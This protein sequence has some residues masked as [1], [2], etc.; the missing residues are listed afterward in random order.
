LYLAKAGRACHGADVTSL[1]PGR[2]AAVATAVLLLAGS[3]AAA[4]SSKSPILPASQPLRL[5]HLA[6]A[7]IEVLARLAMPSLVDY[8]REQH[9]MQG[10]ALQRTSRRL[11]PNAF[12]SRLYLSQLASEQA[13]EVQLINAAVPGATVR[14]RL[15]TVL[16]A[17]A[18]VLPPGA[19]TR[20]A[21]VAGVTH[22]YPQ[23]YYH[24]LTDTV[25]PLVGA[26][27][28][29]GPDMANAGA[30]VKIGI[31]DDGIDKTN[32]FFRP[33]GFTAPAGFPRGDLKDTSNKVIVARAFPPFGADPASKLPFDPKVSEHGTHVAGIA[34]G[35]SGTLGEPKGILPNVPNLSGV[36]P[37]AYLGNYRGLSVADPVYG[38]VGGTSELAAAV[39]KAVQDGMD[40]LN[41]SLGGIE[42]PPQSDALVQA[43]EGAIH[44]GVVVSIAAGNSLQ[45]LGGGS[46]SSP[47]SAPDAI[48]VAAAT[49]NRFFGVTG[50]VV[51][52]GTPPADL[53]H[54]SASVATA[55]AIPAS[56]GAPHAL[57]D[58][59]SLNDAGLCHPLS[60]TPL[61]GKLVLA[62]RG[63]CFFSVTA[64]VARAA[65]A[66]GVVLRNNSATDPFI[67]DFQASLPMLF[68]SR[69]VGDELRAFVAQS[70]GSANVTFGSSVQEV[71]GTPGVLAEFSSE[72]PTPYTHE[73]KPDISAPGVGIL[74]SVPASASYPGSFAVFDGTSMASPAVAGAAALLRETHPS[75]TPA[76]IKSALMGSAIPAY[77]DTTRSAEAS[78][79]REGAGFLQVQGAN[80]P[81][82]LADP[83]SVDFG[84]VNGASADTMTQGIT[85]SDAGDGAGTWTVSVGLQ[86]GAPAGVTV[87]APP[88]VT[89]PASGDGAVTLQLHVPAGAS[90]GDVA[91]FLV[92]TDGTRVRRVPFWG[93]VERPA[94]DPRMPRQMHRLGIFTGNTRDGHS[95]I[96]AYRYP[97]NPSGSAL[98]VHW[99]GPEQLWSFSLTG[100]AI[101][102]GVTIENSRGTRV[103]PI[104]LNQP[105]ENDVAGPEGLPLDVGPVSFTAG[106]PAPAAGMWWV[107]PGLYTV[108]VDSAT[109]KGAGPYR[110]RFWVNDLAPPVVKLLTPIL[111]STPTAHL[112]LSITD[113]ESG[114]DASTVVGF[115]GTSALRLPYDPATGIVSLRARSLKPGKY[116]IAVFATD[117]AQAKDGLAF[118][119][120]ASNAVLK[121]LSFKVV[122]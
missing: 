49:T 116:H 83:P 89:V 22:V 100:P 27:Q 40:V 90:E 71:P 15:R 75:W 37:R 4:A 64:D 65:G 36:A 107:P 39:D 86:P 101:N 109:D 111:R 74:S 79:L 98:P 17:V 88:S 13:R 76:Q 92:L 11:A 99:N 12:A 63:G 54:I 77:N 35:D 1:S 85:V 121:V 42:T 30:G 3:S 60:G 34:A 72:G 115:V 59:A 112:R 14:W 41:L 117:Y 96:T 106:S 32:P 95:R 56:F 113:A 55:P 25:P 57:V 6:P 73:L 102:A 105:D 103:L 81:G 114:V 93:R 66:I 53:Q 51:G 120:S 47:G 61:A 119:P 94:L 19:V 58:A 28:V 5:P 24:E 38:S 67:L 20:L 104:L 52:P 78:P 122:K 118:Q 91:G 50:S 18:V 33:D 62:D 16:D 84:L 69:Q 82:V 21:S 43:V 10:F 97:D 8:A 9:S 80:D 44:A 26:T 23:V 45:E 110:L 29:W 31:I 87:V 46:V 70:S 7:R 68:V 2:I 48:T 108:A